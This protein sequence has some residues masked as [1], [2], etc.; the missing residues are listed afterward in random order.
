MSGR[1]L[2]AVLPLLV[3]AACLAVGRAGFLVAQEVIAQRASSRMRRAVREAVTGH[4]L[5]LG[6]TWLSGER[7]GEVANTVTNGLA[8]LDIWL[9]SYQPARALAAI[10]PCLALLIVLVLDPP[11]ALVLVLTGPVLLLLLAVIGGRAKVIT[12]RRVVELRWL[13]AFFLDMLRGIATLK[14]FG[15]S[16]EQAET[17]REVSDQYGE[18]TMEVLRTAFQTALVLEW[19]GAVATAVVAVE[20]SLRLMAGQVAFGVAMGVLIVTPD[21]FLPLRQLAIRY[22][23]GAAGRSAAERLVALLDIPITTKA[24]AEFD[25]VR[26]VQRSVGST[27]QGRAERPVG[28]IVFRD[29]WA[30]YPDRAPALQGLDLEIGA[31]R[32]VA[33]VGASGAG[34]TT[35]AN[36]LLRFISADRGQIT[37]GWNAIGRA[38]PI[39]VAGRHR[40]GSTAASSSVGDRRR[41]HPPRSPGRDDGRGCHGRTSG[42]CRCLHPALPS[43]YETHLGEGAQRLSGGERQRLAIAR[44]FLRDAPLLILDEPTSHLDAHSEAAIGDAISHLVQGRTVLLISHQLRFVELADEIVVLDAGRAVQSGPPASLRLQDG[45][46]RG[47]SAGLEASRA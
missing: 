43:G 18:T 26:V 33:L 34:K 24:V 42:P 47:L 17:I 1:G 4:L 20:I 44:A 22:H 11:S 36:L 13:S 12:D 3:G 29:V 40:L 39:D 7:M 35:V 27:A 28:D 2:D 38:R 15:R 25:R 9:T 46:Y 5:L 6:P 14:A 23:A 21:F 16:R 31:G 30:S 19:A 8:D 10:V 41:R 37:V 45:P 32:V